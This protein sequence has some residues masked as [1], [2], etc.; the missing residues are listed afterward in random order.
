MTDN[1]ISARNQRPNL[2]QYLH[3]KFVKDIL[4][5]SVTTLTSLFGRHEFYW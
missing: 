5:I 2:A 3:M 4:I 1:M